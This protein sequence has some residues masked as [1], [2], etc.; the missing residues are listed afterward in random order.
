MSS[1]NSRKIAD[2][3]VKQQQPYE[4]KKAY[5]RKRAWEFIDECCKRGLNYH[6]TV[7]GLDSITLFLFLKSIG[8]SD[9]VGISASYLEDSSIQRVHKDLGIVQINPLKD[10]TGRTYTKQRVIEEF[11]FP[12]ISKESSGRIEVLNNPTESNRAY[13]HTIMTGERVVNGKVVKSRYNKL[14]QKWIEKFA[15]KEN[16]NYGTNY[17]V[18]P[19][20]VSDKCCYYLKEKPLELWAKRHNSVPFL[21]LMASEGGRRETALKIH[22]C[23]YFGKKKTRSCPFAIFNRQDL[24]R[25]AL[26]LNVPV[27]EIYGEIKSTNGTLYTTGAERTGCSMCGFGVHLEESPNRF[28]RLKMRNKKEWEYWMFKCCTDEKTG[29]NYGWSRVCDYICVPYGLGDS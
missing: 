8:I 5:A 10:K 13:R 21:G 3:A 28:E 22:G 24:L 4:F 25:L 15:G 1:E 17:R 11:G 23:N 19:F 18:A 2:F 14:P 6:C 7:G 16:E 26:E 9:V 12:V 20:K 29:E 27:P